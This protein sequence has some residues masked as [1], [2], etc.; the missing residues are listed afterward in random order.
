MGRWKGTAAI[1]S[2]QST[3]P[4]RCRHTVISGTRCGCEVAGGRGQA[5]L[6]SDL[7]AT[8]YP[9]LPWAGACRGASECQAVRLDRL[10][11]ARAGQQ[12]AITTCSSLA[13]VGTGK[14]TAW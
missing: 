3:C 10:D 2:R 11:A 1:F 7:F 12:G 8:D 13:G 6:G 4:G 9:P 5:L 14:R